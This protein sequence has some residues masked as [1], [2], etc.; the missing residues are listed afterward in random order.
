MAR[1]AEADVARRPD[2]P[3]AAAKVWTRDPVEIPS[4]DATPAEV[5]LIFGPFFF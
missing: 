2:N 1:K 5:Q 4:T 3:K